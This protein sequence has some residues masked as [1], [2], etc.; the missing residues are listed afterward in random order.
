MDGSTEIVLNLAPGV[1]MINAL[2][3]AGMT[4]S[5]GLCEQVIAGTYTK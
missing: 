2:S 3:G 4:L 1:K 5:F